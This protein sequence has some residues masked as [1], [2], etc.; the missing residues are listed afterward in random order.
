LFLVIRITTGP[1]VGEQAHFLVTIGHQETTHLKL[2][3][4]DSVQIG[5][6]VVNCDSCFQPVNL[7]C[8]M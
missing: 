7:T 6:N 5:L 3:S 8:Q 1:D 2:T 4:L